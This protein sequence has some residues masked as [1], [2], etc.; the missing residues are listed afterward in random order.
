MSLHILKA[1]QSTT[2]KYAGVNLRSLSSG[3]IKIENVN[4]FF[5]SLKINSWQKLLLYSLQ[6]TMLLKYYTDRK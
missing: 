5:S 6:E 3:E 1:H 2:F 4:Q